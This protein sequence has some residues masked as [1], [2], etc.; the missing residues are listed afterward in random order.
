LKY[1]AGKDS[2]LQVTKED[3]VSCNI[4]NPIKHYNDGYTKV[5]FDHSGPYY[6]ISGENGHCEKGQKLTIVVMSQRG[7]SPTPAAPTAIS[8][9]PSPTEVEGPGPAVAPAPTSTA[10]VLQ[11]GGVF[12]A[13]GV[14]V[15][16]WLF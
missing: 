15:A 8:P 4:S 12:V 1:E 3:Y 5:R 7:K 10:T 9:A 2:V 16:M 14:I 6:F 13:I 11:G